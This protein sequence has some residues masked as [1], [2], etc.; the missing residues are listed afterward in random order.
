MEFQILKVQDVTSENQYLFC[1]KDMMDLS[2]NLSG[3]FDENFVR[4]NRGAANG[5]QGR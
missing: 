2:G 5:G 1:V 4:E 3:N